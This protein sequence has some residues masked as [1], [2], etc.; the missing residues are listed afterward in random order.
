M[1]P[2]SPPVRALGRRRFLRTA[3][4]GVTLALGAG[5]G[6][7]P[8]G[9]SAPK[10]RRGAKFMVAGPQAL[11]NDA[12]FTKTLAEIAA[13]NEIE[14]ASLGIPQ[15]SITETTT[16]ADVLATTASGPVDVIFYPI[17]DQASLLT[18]GRLAPLEMLAPGG[19]LGDEADYWPELMRAG[20]VRGK[21][22]GLPV[23]VAPWV[24]MYNVTAF[25]AAGLEPPGK[26]WNWSEFRELAGRLAAD[27]DGD[28]SLDRIG[29]LQIAGGVQMGLRPSIPPSYAWILANGG[30][31]QDDSGSF[32]AMGSQKSMEAVRF[33]ADLI[34]KDRV[35]SAV[36]DFQRFMAIFNANGVGMVSYTVESGQLFFRNLDLPYDLMP[37]P[38]QAEGTIACEINAMAGVAEGSE[39][40]DQS[41]L[42]AVSI[43]EALQGRFVVPARRDA[44]KNVGDIE[45]SLNPVDLEVIL[46][47]MAVTRAVTLSRRQKLV[48]ARELDWPVLR[49]ERQPEEGVAKAAAAL[50]ALE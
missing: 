15:N 29:F 19:D 47:S 22:Y 33:M 28:G 42:A 11:V 18:A 7:F 30:R 8:G 24:F 31:L 35:S 37:F 13:A 17:E 1:S 44:A 27:T 2:V 26:A 10:F 36:A 34:H 45:P 41:Y 6:P 9:P 21:Q 20:R 46:D 50:D 3:A 32:S 43:A 38:L 4:A 48:L 16:F 25:A 5:C 23:L 12:R 39:Y 40:P 14:L 49:G